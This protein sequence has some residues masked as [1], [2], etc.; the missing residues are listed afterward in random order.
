MVCVGGILLLSWMHCFH[1]SI[2]FSFGLV[3]IQAGKALLW[4]NTVCFSGQRETMRQHVKNQPS[5]TRWGLD[6]QC[7]Q[8]EGGGGSGECSAHRQPARESESWWLIS[9]PSSSL[10]RV[11]NA[12]VCTLSRPHQ[13]LSL[14][15]RGEII[16]RSWHQTA[17]ELY[18]LV[19]F[20]Q[21]QSV[22]IVVTGE[23]ISLWWN[24]LC[25]EP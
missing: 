15:L 4:E 13:H 10:S 24:G 5:G 25:S 7:A 16:W 23:G 9:S 1:C 17:S 22:S 3:L 14:R 6:V 2:L 12:M 21:L 8:W 18:I 11:L 19:I 20:P